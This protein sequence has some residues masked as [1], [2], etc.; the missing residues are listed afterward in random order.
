MSAALDR[1][2]KFIHREE[3]GSAIT[4]D[5]ADPGGLTR[6]GVSQRAYPDEDIRNMTEERAKFL[7]ARDY[8][9]PCQCDSLPERVALAVADSAFNQGTRTACTL[10][11]E[12]LRV[13]PDGVIG[14]KTLAAAKA[15]NEADLLNDFLSRRLLRYAKGNEKYRRGWFSRILRVKDATA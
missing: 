8:W 7:F 14:P 4:N 13:D 3:G 11:Q 12:A 2:W 10:L 5:P 1:A 9:K 15:R 6:H